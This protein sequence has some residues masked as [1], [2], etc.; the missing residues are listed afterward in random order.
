MFRGTS[1]NAKND[2]D[3]DWSLLKYED[4]SNA[5]GMMFC[6]MSHYDEK[7]LRGLKLPILDKYF[8]ISP[9]ALLSG[10][11]AIA[12]I[13]AQTEFEFDIL[14]NTFWAEQNEQKADDYEEESG[15]SLSFEEDQG[16]KGAGASNMNPPFPWDG[17]EEEDEKE[18]AKA[19]ALAEL[20][21]LLEEI[22]KKNKEEK[23][24]EEETA[25]QKGSDKDF[26]GGGYS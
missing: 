10:E 18:Q 24:E 4:L 15:N 26:G 22:K 9:G 3:G 8:L 16:F 14:E 12:A 1:G 7:L 6:R 13:A 2:E 19:A 25:K 11:A 21:A 5:T 17:E 23:K 20:L